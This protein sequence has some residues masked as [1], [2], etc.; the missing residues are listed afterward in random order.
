MAGMLVAEELFLLLRRDDGT[1]EVWS[2]GR[3][4]G[5]AA[6]V[7]TDLVLAERVTLSDDKDP[8]V[9][10]L[11]P[12]PAGHPALDAAMVRLEAG[13][14][15]KLSSLVTDRHV[16]AEQQ[17][18]AALAAAGVVRVEAKRAWGLVPAK[19]PVLDP[20]PE[21]RVREH[22]RAALAGSTPRT[23]DATLLAILLALGVA[24]TV[25]KEEKGTL[26]RRDLE[27]RIREIATEVEAGDAVAR[28][29]ATMNSAVPVIISDGGGDGGDGGGGD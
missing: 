8:R 9:S 27:L 3:G 16:A 29:V 19:Y 23:E 1:P 17:L 22:L 15:R 4:Y 11:R 26:D 6:A 2:A 21:R 25:L 14:G 12:G 7:V 5:L 10:V 24:P 13:A 18:A 28:A 20:G